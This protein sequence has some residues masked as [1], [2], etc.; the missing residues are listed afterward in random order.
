MA[1]PESQRAAVYQPEYPGAKKERKQVH[2]IFRKQNRFENII[3]SSYFKMKATKK[4]K[5]PLVLLCVRMLYYVKQEVTGS[6][7]Q[8]V[9]GG[10]DASDIDVWVPEP[11]HSEVPAEWWDF[12]ADK[13]LLI[14]VLKH[15][16]EK[17]N[18]IRADPALCFLERVG[19]PDEKAVAAEQRANDFMDGN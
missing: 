9:F 18:T 1:K 3:L 13:S 11:D 2:L 8:K 10:V 17:Y 14:G 6:E 15:G 4:H 5:T 19:K 12:D 16:Y 7:C